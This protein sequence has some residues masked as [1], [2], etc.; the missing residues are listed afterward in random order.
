MGAPFELDARLRMLSALVPACRMAADIGADHGFLGAQLLLSGQCE[1][2]QF[3]DVSAPSL[4]KARRLIASLS[5]AERALFSVGD[6]AQALLAPA[7]AVIIAGMGGP[8]ICGILARGQEQ[9]GDAQLILQANMGL[10]ELR[11][12]LVRLHYRIDREELTRAGG[13]WYIGMR[14]VRGEAQY[15]PLELLAGPCLLKDRHP[16]LGEYAAFRIRV[17]DKALCGVLK[18]QGERAAR[19]ERELNA[20]KRL[21]EEARQA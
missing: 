15:S 2:V 3:L 4:Q 6:G 19:I 13:R 9:L 5:F 7:E 1:R 10:R 18:T 21:W 11:E 17:L 12:C 14:A 8:T 20:E 16:L